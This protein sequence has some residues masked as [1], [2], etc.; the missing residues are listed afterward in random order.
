MTWVGAC[1]FARRPVVVVE[2]H[3]HHVGELLRALAAA[4]PGLPAQATVACLDRPGPDTQ[5]AVAGW[6]A[7]HPH[8]QVAAALDGAAPPARARALE[9]EVFASAQRF[10]RAVAGLLRPGGLL[11]QDVQLSTLAFVPADRWWESI[12]LASTVRGMF[13]AAPPVCWFLS[14]KRGYEATFGRDLVEAGFNPRDVLDKRDL[15]TVV[16]PVVRDFLARA[17]PLVLAVAGP[18]AERPPEAVVAAGPG[19]AG[20]AGD[21]DRPEIDSALDLVLWSA[22]GPTVDL[23][24]RLLE[25]RVTLKV[26]SQEAATWQALVADRFAGGEGVPVLEVGKRVAPEGAGRAEQTNLAARHLHLLRGRLKDSAAVVT[27][28]HAYRLAEGLAVGRV[29]PRSMRSGGGRRGSAP[30]G[31]G[32]ERSREAPRP[33]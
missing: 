17:F 25:R 20:T 10:A 29:E 3:L 31:G 16:A 7:A 5:A 13:P 2:D 4:D 9:P 30:P 23:A 18:G 32:S 6:L 15:A 28:R 11:L 8:L 27:E 26:G 1:S 14:N 33:S 22:G 12:Y 24:G 21:L 19:T